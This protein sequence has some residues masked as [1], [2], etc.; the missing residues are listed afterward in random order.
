MRHRW[1]HN[2]NDFMKIPLYYSP[3]AFLEFYATSPTP[4]TLFRCLVSL[5]KCVITPQ[6]MCYFG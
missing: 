2:P 3:P 4:P 5:A 1:H 6:L